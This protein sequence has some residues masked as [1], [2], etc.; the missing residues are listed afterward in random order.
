MNC[1]VV[2]QAFGRDQPHEQSPLAGV[3][4][5]VHGHHVLVHGQLVPVA[6]DDV[7]HVVALQ[8]HRKVANGPTTELHEENVSVSR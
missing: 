1:L 4:G 7:A 6:V 2:L 3:V 8:R 5:R